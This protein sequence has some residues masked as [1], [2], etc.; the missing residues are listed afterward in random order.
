[1]KNSIISILLLLLVS[2]VF[3]QAPPQALNYSAIAK[4]SNGQMLANKVIGL[5][6]TILAGGMT[7][8][9]VYQETQMD[10]TGPSG[11]FN[12]AIGM[13][14][15]VQGAFASISWGSNTHFLKVEL[16]ENGGN[17]YFDV[18][19]TQ[20]LSVPYA[21]YAE[22][23]GSLDTT[24]AG[25]SSSYDLPYGIANSTPLIDSIYSGN[26]YTVPAGKN[27]YV[28]TFAIPGPNSGLTFTVDGATFNGFS[29]TNYNNSGFMTLGENM[30]MA[31]AV[32]TINIIGYLTDQTKDII[33]HDLAVSDYTVPVGKTL[34]V[35]NYDIPWST[36]GSVTVDG[37]I[38]WD[39]RVVF[40]GQII[41]GASGRFIG[42]LINQ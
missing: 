18:G 9:V 17:N 35:T 32:D 6:F 3:A 2:I 23:A 19:T 39:I 8:T 13:G 33:V 4:G 20:L 5:R 40:S 38:F 29:V 10:T 41:S 30:V 27:L 15:V 36:F 24:G 7:G 34:V 14:T 12:L 26:P 1:M 42:Y 11:V 21:L 22:S 16:D 37:V 28:V 31:T 25:N